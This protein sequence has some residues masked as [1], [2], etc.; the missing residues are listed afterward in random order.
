MNATLKPGDRVRLKNTVSFGTVVEV[1]CG[2]ADELP[3]EVLVEWD[4]HEGDPARVASAELDFVR[5]P[6]TSWPSLAV[7]LAAPLFLFDR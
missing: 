4:G 5:P 7:P 2:V 6:P 1:A 3:S